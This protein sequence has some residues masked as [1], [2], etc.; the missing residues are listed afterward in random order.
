MRRNKKLRIGNF[1]KDIIHSYGAS[2]IN[3][4]YSNIPRLINVLH[5]RIHNDHE[6][7]IIDHEEVYI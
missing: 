3:N 7:L 6:E 4:L 1:W 5:D 2:C